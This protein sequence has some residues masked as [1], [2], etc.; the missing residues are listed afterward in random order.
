MFWIVAYV[1]EFEHASE[2]H[3]KLV[4]RPGI[5]WRRLRPRKRCWQG[6]QVQLC[7]RVQ[8]NRN[9]VFRRN[10]E[11]HARY[12]FDLSGSEYVQIQPRRRA[13][14]H[15][16]IRHSELML[17]NILPMNISSV[18]AICTCEFFLSCR[19]CWCC[20]SHSVAAYSMA[21][22]KRLSSWWFRFSLWGSMSA[23]VA[24]NLGA[25]GYTAMA[26]CRDYVC[27]SPYT[28]GRMHDAY[29]HEVAHYVYTH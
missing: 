15:K 29:V 3:R 20:I 21:L 18:C 19:V 6:S 12:S 7:H 16:L 27:T 4:V 5:A 13:M 26:G 1:E 2:Q 9:F 8:W 25:N 17:N 14:S 28:Y 11:D 10:W 23:I 24:I 22:C